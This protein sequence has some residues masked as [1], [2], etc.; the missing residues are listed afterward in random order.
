MCE[1]EVLVIGLFPAD[2][3]NPVIRSQHVYRFTLAG[4]W[5]KWDGSDLPVKLQ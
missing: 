3:P 5:C 2:L 4:S 1:L